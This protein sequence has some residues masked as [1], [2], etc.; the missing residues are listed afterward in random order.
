MGDDD[1]STVYAAELHGIEM[2][3]NSALESTV[4]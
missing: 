2:A 3:L 1:T 4:P